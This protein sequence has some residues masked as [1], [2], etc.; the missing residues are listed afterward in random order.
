MLNLTIKQL[1]EITQGRRAVGSM[2]PLDG[3]LQEIRRLI[4]LGDEVLEGDVV[5]IG[6]SLDRTAHGFGESAFV[7]GAK[8]VICSGPVTP[9][10]GTFA[11]NVPCV[12]TALSRLA[13]WHRHRFMGT[14][15][16]VVEES[17]GAGPW[18]DLAAVGLHPHQ[19]AC[20]SH[21]LLWQ[22]LQLDTNAATEILACSLPNCCHRSIQIAAPD[23]LVV[24]SRESSVDTAPSDFVTETLELDVS[25]RMLEP[26]VTE[27]TTIV[28]PTQLTAWRTLAETR[29]ANWVP[30]EP[31]RPGS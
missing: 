22:L 16:A 13:Q 17:E 24:P 15:V 10:D 18:H 1:T 4:P 29:A 28:A 12:R 25:V 6:G 21:D 11:V 5:V 27:Q 7:Q 19:S 14:L 23:I 2:P 9:W 3:D 8:G 30:Y 31:Q 20:P 26:V